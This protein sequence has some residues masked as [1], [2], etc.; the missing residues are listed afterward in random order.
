MSTGNWRTAPQRRIASRDAEDN[1]NTKPTEIA[2]VFAQSVIR[3]ALSYRRTQP[4]ASAKLWQG[5]LGRGYAANDLEEFARSARSC[6]FMGDARILQAELGR[7]LQA[8]AQRPV[9]APVE[10]DVHL[11]SR[12]KDPGPCKPTPKS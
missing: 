9:E 6:F 1:A 10:S 7:G 11:R 5:L 12:A 8:P 2:Q 3:L 4:P